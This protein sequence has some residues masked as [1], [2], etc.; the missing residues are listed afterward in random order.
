MNN[1]T[2]FAISSTQQFASALSVCLKVAALL[3]GAVGLAGCDDDDYEDYPPVV[4]SPY[5]VPNSVAVGDFNGDAIN[6]VV[7]AGTRI[8]RASPNPGFI[9]L[10]YQTATAGIFQNSIDM[11]TRAAN[12][13]ILVAADLNKAGALDFAVANAYSSNVSLFMSATTAGQYAESLN[14]TTG[15][16]PLSVDAGDLNGDTFID[17]AVAD[18]S[19]SG[20]VV[21][22][23]QDGVTAGRFLVPVSMSLPSPAT[24]VA[25]GEING[26]GRLDIVATSQ[27]SY[28]QGTV[29]LFIQ[30]GSN[31]GQ[32]AAPVNLVSGS[33]PYA[34]KM[35]DLNA[36]GAN[37]LV[38][39]NGGSTYGGNG[40]S[41]VSVLI[42]S[43][44]QRGQF[45]TPVNYAT[46]YGAVD[47]VVGDLNADSR[48]D[49][50]VAN[51]SRFNPSVSVLLQ[52]AARPGMYLATTNYP[53]Y[54]E[55]LGVAIGDLNR[56]NLPDIAVADG[57]R[58][59]VMFQSTT[60]AGTFAN[61]TRIGG[62][63]IF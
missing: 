15:G 40:A 27:D 50:V 57:N 32:F 11:A 14:I 19:S 52:D 2:A 59:T 5:N 24:S 20:K 34:I 48:P 10:I 9:G 25:I 13:A 47:V 58:A 63:A 3:C 61:P 46:G 53:T 30:S 33:Q 28:G 43:I 49:L 31:P 29:S 6:D 54:Y 60:T 62:T 38:I 17:L 42:Q 18:G 23:M 1:A 51:A 22:V 12:P 36:D 21:L 8:D 7:M 45:A 4:I 16:A 41:G 26:D 39:A 37:D 35:A 44:T 55:P 56:D